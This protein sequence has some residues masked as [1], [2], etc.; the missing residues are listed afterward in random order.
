MIDNPRPAFLKL[1]FRHIEAK[2]NKFIAA[3][4][5]DFLLTE[6]EGDRAGQSHDQTIARPMPLLIVDRFQA[7][8][9]KIDDADG[10]GLEVE[11]TLHT[12][13]ALRL[14]TPVMISE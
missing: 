11:G 1:R 4:A 10:N 9:I 12:F 5:V 2:D 8:E 7:V 6:K 13:K 14:A 3:R